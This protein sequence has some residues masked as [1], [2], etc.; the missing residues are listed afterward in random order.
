MTG[1]G[2]VENERLD[3]VPSGKVLVVEDTDLAAVMVINT[4]KQFQV[5]SVRA[6]SGQAGIDLA[7][8]EDFDFILM[9]IGLPDINGL[10]ASRKIL[11]S[12]PN[13]PIIALTA[14]Y[15]NQDNPDE[16]KEYGISETVCKPL[17]PDTAKTLIKKY[18]NS[19]NPQELTVI[20][21]KSHAKHFG[22]TEET[23]RELLT[24]LIK[25]LRSD[26][27]L[28]KEYFVTTNFKALSAKVHALKGALMYVAAPSLR[29]SCSQL[30]RLIL[31]NPDSDLI[32]KSLNKFDYE[33]DRLIE[34]FNSTSV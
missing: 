25:T 9:D 1:W 19:N 4:L 6:S 22:M 7:L 18:I 10:D 15:T 13:T 33:T 26:V 29:E 32:K 27:D 24:V 17:S 21:L 31:E 8:N 11:R 2:S 23:S 20:D 16:Y 14:G 34:H 3:F 5:A 30:Y 28:I 12:K